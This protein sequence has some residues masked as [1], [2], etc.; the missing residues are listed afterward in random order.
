MKKKILENG[1]VLLTLALI[2][3]SI[4]P[5]ALSYPQYGEN[6]TTSGNATITPTTTATA[7]ITTT[8][9]PTET[10]TVDPT[11]VDPTTV[12]P[13]TVEPAETVRVAD[14]PIPVPTKK[15]PAIGIIAAIGIIG[16]IYIIR[17][18]K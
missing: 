7:E 5:G 10:L 4:V 17:K 6:A 3:L 11:T 8:G 2:I 16:T 1:L 13:T 14:A 18:M 15:S 9:T 12:D